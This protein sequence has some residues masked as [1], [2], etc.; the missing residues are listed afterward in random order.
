MTGKEVFEALV[1][2]ARGVDCC[3]EDDTTV[4]EESSRRE[5]GGGQA[6]VAGPLFVVNLSR[7]GARLLIVV[8]PWGCYEGLP[9][10]AE[11]VGRLISRSVRWR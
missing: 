1:R 9:A 2:F 7:S 4:V 8:T 6:S 3:S 5:Q 11:R 10:D